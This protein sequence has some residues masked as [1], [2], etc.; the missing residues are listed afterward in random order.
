MSRADTLLKIKEAESK[1]QEIMRQAEEQ[2][3]AIISSARRDAIR[4][5]QEADD[6]MKVEFDAALASEKAKIASQ[7]QE[8]L[9]KGSEEADRLKS[10]AAI[11]I[12]KAK[13]FMKES[14]ERTVD[15]TS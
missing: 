1:A 6:K 3:K 9:K 12:P 15:A 10:K 14:F 11:N 5:M 13:K 7:R 8:T 4:M 2:Q